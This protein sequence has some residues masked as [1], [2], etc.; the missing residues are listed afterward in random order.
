MAKPNY[1]LP[2]T[3]LSPKFA[4]KSSHEAAINSVV[5]Q[6]VDIIEAADDELSDRISSIVAG[7]VPV[8]EW[9]A[10]SGAFPRGAQIIGTFY[11]VPEGGAGTV[12]GVAF[13]VGDQLLPLVT[14]S[15]TSTYAGNWVRNP[16]SGIV[17][18][19]YD[20]ANSFGASLEAERGVGALWETKEGFRYIE[21]ASEATDY[22]VTTEGGVKLYIHEDVVR[23]DAFV[24]ADLPIPTFRQ[25]EVRVQLHASK[26]FSAGDAQNNKAIIDEIVSRVPS[27]ATIKFLP[28]DGKVSLYPL[29]DIPKTLTIDLGG[30][31][32]VPDMT[33]GDAAGYVA[34]ATGTGI[35]PLFKFDRSS[36]A[37]DYSLTG[38][39]TSGALTIEVSVA[40]AAALS[41]GDAFYL[42]SSETIP[43]WIETGS[44]GVGGAHRVAAISGTIMTLDRPADWDYTS[45][46]VLRTIPEGRPVVRN[47]YIM[48][49]DTAS[50]YGG[51]TA[52]SNTPN[53]VHF[54]YCDDFLVEGVEFRNVNINAVAVQG[55]ASGLVRK[56]KG[57]HAQRPDNGGHG[58]LVKIYA[59]FS[60]NIR[61]EGNETVFMRHLYD[62]TST[63]ACR[64]EGNVARAHVAAPYTTHGYGDHNSKSV[65]DEAVNCRYGW[66]IGREDFAADYGFE[67]INSIS[68]GCFAPFWAV[69]NVDGLKIRGGSHKV[70]GHPDGRD[71]ERLANITGFMPEIVVENLTVTLSGSISAADSLIFIN[72]NPSADSAV[73]RPRNVSV[74]NNRIQ[75]RGDLAA[76]VSNEMDGY[77]EVSNNT[78]ILPGAVAATGIRVQG[79]THPAFVYST[80]N[81]DMQG[82][83]G[84][85]TFVE[86]GPGISAVVQD[87]IQTASET[88]TVS[89]VPYRLS[90]L[91]RVHVPR[92]DATLDASGAETALVLPITT[93]GTAYE[94]TAINRSGGGHTSVTRV[95]MNPNGTPNLSVLNQDSL[96]ADAPTLLIGST[97]IEVQNNAASER[98]IIW[99][100]EKKH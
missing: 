12:D 34:G 84:Q 6:L 42:A 19:V 67:V 76:V 14:S 86:N 31:I 79:T 87:D 10:S 53:L 46:L 81:R 18:R 59:P 37:V 5:S 80:G 94:I 2:T 7:F 62:F 51:S 32:L 15:S 74:R 57:L 97:D 39:I 64:G 55:C 93:D 29:D 65:N 8:G 99:F 36:D 17:D 3:C 1:V 78:Y 30:N 96:H 9:D 68:S 61:V 89:A 26:A 88:N 44:H 25:N 70:G 77:L 98:I 95:F 43:F 28:V 35:K 66:G 13:A 22:H 16:R 54:R 73:R 56:C 72:H 45:N 50:T 71:N 40:A 58:N 23:A 85:F 52:G 21:A 47:G 33:A 100:V 27:N 48:E 38:P 24:I 63:A 60:A 69:G 4:A 49:Q 20:S 83:G 82:G 91:G 75:L 90:N 92:A 41:P 11:I